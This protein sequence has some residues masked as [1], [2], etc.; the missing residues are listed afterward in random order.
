VYVNPKHDITDKVIKAEFYR[1]IKP[2][3]KLKP[4]W[5][6]LLPIWSPSLTFQTLLR[7]SIL[8]LIS[9]NRIRIDRLSGLM[10]YGKR[11][12]LLPHGKSVNEAAVCKVIVHPRPKC[13]ELGRGC[14]SGV[15]DPTTIF[16]LSI[17]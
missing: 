1:Y 8:T 5:T 16:A 10:R 9:T 14:A 7:P 17:Q 3:V 12:Q 15:E 6:L 13:I 11:S 2:E 4:H